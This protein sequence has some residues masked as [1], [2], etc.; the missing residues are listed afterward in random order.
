[1]YVHTREDKPLEIVSQRT[2]IRVGVQRMREEMMFIRVFRG[3]G[4][5]GVAEIFGVWCKAFGGGAFTRLD[6]E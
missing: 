2:C 1:M 4:V 5:K 6:D 3:T